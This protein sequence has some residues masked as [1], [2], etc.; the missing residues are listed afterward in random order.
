MCTT[1]LA[2]GMLSEGRQKSG[3]VGGWREGEVGRETGDIRSLPTKLV[4]TL[5][6]RANAGIQSV[7]CI[8]DGRRAARGCA[9]ARA[10][11]RARRYMKLIMIPLFSERNASPSAS[12]LF[13]FVPSRRRENARKR[14]VALNAFHNSSRDSCNSS[15]D[16]KNYIIASQSV[17]SS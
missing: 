5:V 6:K 3:G 9:C 11:A 2:V 1:F 8:V 13:L 15:R 7:K 16:T 14:C 12:L 4:S 17:A 10:R